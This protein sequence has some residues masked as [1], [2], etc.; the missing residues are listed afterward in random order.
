MGH[1]LENWRR[2]PTNCRGDCNWVN[3]PH[4]DVPHPNPLRICKACEQYADQFIDMTG[5]KGD[6]RGK[7]KG[8]GKGRY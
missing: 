7:G 5:G 3:C 6:G 1:V 8:K 4:F 2:H